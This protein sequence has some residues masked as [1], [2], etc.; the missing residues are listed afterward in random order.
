MDAN[1]I[2]AFIKEL[3]TEKNMTQKDLAE[4]INCTDKAISRWETGKGVPEVSL[5]IP[6]SK[7]LNVSVNELLS[8]ERFILESKPEEQEQYKDLVMVPVIMGKSDETIV[9]VITEKENE[10]RKTKKDTVIFMILCC[11]QVL[12][13]FVIPSLWQ[14]HQ[15]WD[16]AEFLVLASMINAFLVG[17]VD[18]KIK[19]IFP[20]FGTLIVISAIIFGD[21]EEL[22][23]ISFSLYFA[24]GAAIIMAL[25]SVMRFLVKLVKQKIK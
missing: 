12:I 15:G 2:G 7:T 13:F 23:G 1:K 5:L 24:I 6:L 3:R 25:S 9:D 20:F 18:D 22:M 11:V 19:W 21:G 10:L 4:K 16:A 17:L 14:M 8:G